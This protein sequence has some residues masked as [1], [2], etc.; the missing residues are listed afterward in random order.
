MRQGEAFWW[1]GS[2][3]AIERP[4]G[5][6]FVVCDRVTFGGEGLSYALEQISGA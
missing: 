4:L 3:Y 2:G 5:R 1:K 6:A